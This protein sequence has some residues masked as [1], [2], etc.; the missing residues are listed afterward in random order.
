MKN[1]VFLLILLMPMAAYADSYYNGYINRNGNYVQPHYQTA[2]D[3]TMFN[4]YSTK[5]NVNPYNGNLGTV[6]PYQPHNNGLGTHNSFNN[7]H[8]LYG[9]HGGR[10]SR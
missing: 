8:S 9:S 3:N 5:G 10:R 1:F 7:S 6:N 4:N 2:P